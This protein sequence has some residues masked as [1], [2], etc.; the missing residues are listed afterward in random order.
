M[1]ENLFMPVFLASLM[2][3]VMIIERPTGKRQVALGIALALSYLTR[4]IGVLLFVPLIL[5]LLVDALKAATGE[6]PRSISLVASTVSKFSKSV[7]ERWMVLV[8]FLLFV[9]PLYIVETAIYGPSLSLVTGMDVSLAPRLTSLALRP[10]E[11]NGVLLTEWFVIHFNYG[12]VAV[13]IVLFVTSAMLLGLSR[14]LSPGDRDWNLFLYALVIL[15]TYAISVFMASFVNLSFSRELPN[16]YLAGR[17]VDP[18]LPGLVVVGFIGLKKTREARQRYLCPML[19]V[20]C[21]TTI[22]ILSVPRMWEKVTPP[23]SIG[24]NYVPVYA[25]NYLGISIVVLVAILLVGAC[26][27][28]T[29]FYSVR[30]VSWKQAMPLVAI[31][32]LV[33]FFFGSLAAYDATSWSAGYSDH[34]LHISAWVTE[35]DIRNVTL[36][37]DQRFPALQD[38][39]IRIDFGIRFWAGERNIRVFV[40]NITAP[41]GAD[42]ILSP[43]HLDLPV[44]MSYVSHGTYYYI[45]QAHQAYGTVAGLPLTFISS[46]SPKDEIPDS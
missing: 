21:L 16:L 1:S 28:M 3:E 37:V 18:T 23:C 36:L 42:Y 34:E 33:F 17:Y 29:A 13:G 6:K 41:L 27:F 44:V 8:T 32:L 38:V 35:N 43:D 45:Y 2:L 11:L 40:G 5:L 19:F 30:R 9:A 12:V 31:C 4:Y 10:S 7:A 25:I 24:I 22:S 39:G 26:V 14:R 20:F 46:A 15:A